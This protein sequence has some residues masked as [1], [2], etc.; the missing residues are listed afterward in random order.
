M[1]K[2][3][4][5]VVGSEFVRVSYIPWTGMIVEIGIPRIWRMIGLSKYDFS[6]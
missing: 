2:D 6:L 3:S 1:S 5:V 4:L